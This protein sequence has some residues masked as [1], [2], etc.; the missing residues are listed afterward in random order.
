[1]IRAPAQVWCHAFRA[2]F[3]FLQFLAER[4]DLF[5]FTTWLRE[6]HSH[7]VWMVPCQVN[8]YFMIQYITR[9]NHINLTP[10][11]TSLTSADLLGVRILQNLHPAVFVGMYKIIMHTL[12]LICTCSDQ[13]IP[14][15]LSW[16]H[17]YTCICK[18]MNSSEVSRI[19]GLCTDLHQH[20][21]T[22]LE[23]PQNRPNPPIHWHQVQYY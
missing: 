17:W 9:Q 23:N 4:I 3:F 13:F 20:D 6:Q 15:Y 14:L 1:M 16:N 18:P 2:V 11:E 22:F 10:T 21:Q 12:V 7:I 8:R 19:A 5:C